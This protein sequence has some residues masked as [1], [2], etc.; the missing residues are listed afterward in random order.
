MVI[1]K[2]QRLQF[3]DNTGYKNR[4]KS[5]NIQVGLAIVSIPLYHKW[6]LPSATFG[7]HTTV[8]EPPPY[9]TV[10]V[11]RIWRT[12]AS[13][14]RSNTKPR[15]IQRRHRHYSHLPIRCCGELKEEEELNQ[16]RTWHQ[17]SWNKL[18]YVS[19]FSTLDNFSL[20]RQKQDCKTQFR[21]S[22]LVKGIFPLCGPSVLR[23]SLIT[24]GRQI[25]DAGESQ[26]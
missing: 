9:T 1:N 16:A 5:A 20:L 24:S 4:Y 18:I 17:N 25:E 12:P 13:A 26:L 22:W 14:R 11:G 21:I 23:L 8:W 2:R 10:V 3:H 19:N 6:T 7:T 15:T